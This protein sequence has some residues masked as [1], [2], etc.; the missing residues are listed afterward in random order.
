MDKD[1]KV[2]IRG[3]VLKKNNNSE[4]AFHGEG[5]SGNNPDNPSVASSESDSE[6]K[7]KN[8]NEKKNDNVK[9]KKRLA[10]AN[11]RY[12]RRYAL[13]IAVLSFFFVLYLICMVFLLFIVDREP[14]GVYRYNFEP[15]SE[16]KRNISLWNTSG[17]KLYVIYNLFGNVICFMPFGFFVP[18]IFYSKKRFLIVFLSSFSFTVLIEVTQLLTRVGSFDIDDII[19]NTV[20]GIFGF[21]VYLIIKKIYRMICGTE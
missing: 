21:I 4:G 3:V 18:A 6:N 1:K 8:D 12:T 20:G 16:I 11:L 17:Y 15:F 19:L 10:V 7:K 5:K 14:S 9:K 2:L 13:R